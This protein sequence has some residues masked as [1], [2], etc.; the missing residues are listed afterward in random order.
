MMNPIPIFDGHNDTLLS[1]FDG[2]HGKN[3]SF[4][5]WGESGHLDLPRG[6]AGGYKGG[7][8][9][10]FCPPPHD[11]PDHDPFSRAVFSA[12]GYQ[13]PPIGGIDPAYAERL[14]DEVIAFLGRLLDQ[15]WGQIGLVRTGSD[16]DHLLD[17][18]M[19]A[20]VLHLEGAEAIHE[21]LDNLER[22]YEKGVRSIGLVWSRPNV[23]GCGIQYSFPGS[24]DT[25][26]GLTRQGKELVRQCNRL[27]VLVDL[28][29]INEKGFWDVARI[30]DVPLVV[31]H[32]GIHALSP[33]SRNL[34]D[35]E[36]DAVGASGGLV[37]IMFEPSELREDGQPNPDTPLETLV[38]HIDYVAQRIGSDHVALG[39]DF[40][41]AQMPQELKDAAGLPK[42]MGALEDAGYHGEDLAKITSGNWLRILR[43]RLGTGA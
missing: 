12:T 2:E 40:D 23:F 31:S 11:S 28:A 35:A 39:S 26:D 37:G 43:E 33:A 6:R 29:H 36:I 25:G 10:I 1:L 42:L 8:F 3:R 30:S 9:A 16:L 24:P 17:N 32:T 4:F 38:R 5:E 7:L 15:G 22:Y 34:T 41:G 21:N 14:T 13:M 27:G 18:D 20:M 19:L